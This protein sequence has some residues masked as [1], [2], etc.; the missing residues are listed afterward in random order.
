MFSGV[1]PLPL[2]ITS[3]HH[4]AD[5]EQMLVEGGYFIENS[6]EFVKKKCDY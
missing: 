1:H 3:Q 2:S 4:V 5:N 6:D